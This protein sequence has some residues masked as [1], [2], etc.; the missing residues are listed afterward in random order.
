MEKMGPYAAMTLGMGLGL[1]FL[2]VGYTLGT[3]LHAAGSEDPL[4]SGRTKTRPARERSRSPERLVRSPRMSEAGPPTEI[5][6]ASSSTNNLRIDHI[7]TCMSPSVMSEEVAGED[8]DVQETIVAGRK[9]VQ[10]VL[11][12]RDDRLICIVGP[13]SIHDTKAAMEYADLLA[14]AVVKYNEDLV[15]VMRVYFEKPRTTVGWKGLINDP[16][17]DGSN[18]I[19]RGL[20]LARSILCDINRLGVPCATEFLDTISP[21]YTADLV[22]WGAIGARTTESQVH[23]ELASGLSMPVGFKNGTNGDLQIAADAIKA[24]N[25]PHCFLSV[26]SQGQVAI[27]KTSGNMDSHIILRGGAKGPNYDKESIAATVK[28]LTDCKVSQKIIVDCSHG[29][30]RKVHTNQP[31]VAEDLAGQISA[32]NSNICGVMLESN[33]VEGAQADPLKNG[34]KTLVYGQSI[35]DSCINWD[36]TEKVLASLAAAV[37]ARRRMSF[38]HH[39]TPG[40]VK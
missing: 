16:S 7:R 39:E 2:T 17:L 30:S 19:N 35:T 37:R 11:H 18:N 13:C 9:A 21:Q 1:G 12:N 23:R 8:A 32:G 4:R 24:A 6:Y 34:G 20:R 31:F 28:L 36:T 38:H 22:T 25:F 14:S 3:Q 5:T 33:L 40:Y 27:V 10:D 29:N 26:T 15:V